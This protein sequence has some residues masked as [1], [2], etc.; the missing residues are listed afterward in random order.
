VALK[1]LRPA[2]AATLGAERFLREIHVAASLAHPNILVVHD[3]GDA[4]GTLYY[5]MPYVEGE[6]LRARVGRKDEGLAWAR[7][8]V[9]AD[10]EDAGVRY[11]VACLYSLEG[12][13]EEAIG[14]L[15][16]AFA[17]GFANRDW[18]ERDPD[19]NPLREHPRFQ[20]LLAR[21]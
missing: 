6:S 5:V 18:I 13:I 17:M 20:A 3:S 21:R 19:L 4:G 10:P 11:N 9:A 12:R 16:D 14:C 2:I 1:V 15:E 8:A 7:Q